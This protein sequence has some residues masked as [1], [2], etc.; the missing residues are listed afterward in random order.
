MNIFNVHVNRIPYSG[1]VSMISYKKGNFSAANLD[2]AST[3]N[4]RNIVRIKG[5][6]G[7]ELL[8]VQIAGLIA[9]RI[10]CWV[11]EGMHVKKGERFGMIRFGSC[12]ELYLPADCII[13]VKKGDKVVAGETPVGCLK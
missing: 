9:R 6:D 8:V 2:K 13:S 4:E 12:V 7:T 10:V 1:Q 3:S 5:D 11:T